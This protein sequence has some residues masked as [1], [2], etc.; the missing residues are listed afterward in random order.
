MWRGSGK[1]ENDEKRR[2]SERRPRLQIRHARMNRSE[3]WGWGPRDDDDDDACPILRNPSPLTGVAGGH[4]GRGA[5]EDELT[6]PNIPS[7]SFGSHSHESHLN[8][9]P[10]L[11]PS[12]ITWSWSHK[13]G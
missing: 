6:G 7:P 8:L 4:G 12:L 10:T 13:I 2:H 3:C 5:S 11:G 1:R 9:T